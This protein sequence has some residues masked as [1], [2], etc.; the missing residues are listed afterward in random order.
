MKTF[1]ENVKA[2]ILLMI[3]AAIIVFSALAEL[4]VRWVF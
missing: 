1:I 2:V 3:L 4:G